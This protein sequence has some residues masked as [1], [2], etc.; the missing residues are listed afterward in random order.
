M[1]QTSS[2]LFIDSRKSLKVLKK[3]LFTLFNKCF[4][5][6]MC[7]IN[8]ILLR[9]WWVVCSSFRR[10]FMGYLWAILTSQQLLCSYVKLLKKLQVGQTCRYISIYEQVSTF[11]FGTKSR[12]HCALCGMERKILKRIP[13]AATA[14]GFVIF[15]GVVLIH[16]SLK[17]STVFPY[18]RAVYS[19]FTSPRWKR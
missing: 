13:Q 1:E 17:Q 10:L 6:F 12:R 8:P 7:C 4:L 15:F 14:F 18:P 5:M 3:M 2:S 9:K 11:Y 16:N 19:L